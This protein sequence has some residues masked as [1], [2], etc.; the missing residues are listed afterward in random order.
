MTSGQPIKVQI[1]IVNDT[2]VLVKD[3][4]HP[5][6]WKL[7]KVISVHP[8]T[9]GKVRTVTLQTFNGQFTSLCKKIGPLQFESNPQEI[10]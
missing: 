1:Y 9:D 4:I 10:Y 2:V 3:N 8:G 5:L 7:G 6:H